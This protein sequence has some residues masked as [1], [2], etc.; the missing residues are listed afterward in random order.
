LDRRVARTGSG[1]GVSAVRFVHAGGEEI[2]E[3]DAAS[4]TVLR[5]RRPATLREAA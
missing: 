1:A 3:V 4:S 5:K 2:A